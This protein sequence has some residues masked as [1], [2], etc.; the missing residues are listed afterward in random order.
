MK[1]NGFLWALPFVFMTASCGNNSNSQTATDEADLVEEVVSDALDTQDLDSQNDAAYTQDA[2]A[3]VDSVGDETDLVEEPDSL[4]TSDGSELDVPDE[5]DTGDP[6]VGPLTI[7][8]WNMWHNGLSEA[9]RAHLASWSPD[10]AFLLDSDDLERHQTLLSEQEYEYSFDASEGG[11]TLASR[12]PYEEAEIIDPEGFNHQ[13]VHV[14]FIIDDREI[15]MFQVHFRNPSS[16][17]PAYEQ[18]RWEAGETL[19]MIDEM[20]GHE[21][22]IVLGDFN[23]LATS[24]DRTEYTFT[25]DAFIE[26][27]YIDTYRHLNADSFEATKI[28]RSLPGERVDYVFVSSD[29]DDT[30]VGAGIQL[31]TTYP[32]HSDHRAVW[33]EIDFRMN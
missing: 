9:N 13:I 29:L 31:G 27:G 11:T 1:R 20:T 2:D 5:S 17:E 7:Y 22:T 24:D 4:D 26:A 15:D 25:T 14:R 18:Q 33:V 6:V 32:E 12:I 23:A 16:G 28:A 21:A 3:T 10:I 30:L 8:A 19:A